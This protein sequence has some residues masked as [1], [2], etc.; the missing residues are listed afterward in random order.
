MNVERILVAE[1]DPVTLRFVSSLLLEKGYEVVEAEDGGQAFDLAVDKV[2][3]LIISDLVMPYRDGF[4]L[5][6]ALRGD[7]R[8]KH[9]PVII[10]SMKD[11]ENDIVRGLEQGA[12]DYIVKP[13]NARELLA[14]VKKQLNRAARG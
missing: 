11:R 14:R 7:R 5:L 13:F 12:D 1:D 6:R 2:P 4:G 8:L 3:D 9:V 10:L